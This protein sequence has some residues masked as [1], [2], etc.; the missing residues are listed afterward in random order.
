MI[1]VT[2]AELI[3]LLLPNKEIVIL[4][5]LEKKLGRLIGNLSPIF[6]SNF[7]KH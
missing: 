6:L 7:G 4:V 3:V 1:Y 5:V 2:N